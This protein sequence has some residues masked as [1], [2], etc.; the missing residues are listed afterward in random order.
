[1][2]QD[3]LKTLF[4]FICLVLLQ[5]LI[6][7]NVNLFGF[8]NPAFYLF[9]IIIYRFD[10]SKFLLILL[11]FSLGLIIDLFQNSSGAN[12]IATL[13]ISFIRPLMIRFSFGV[14]PD[15]I[16][17]FSMKSRIDSQVL[18][19]I[20]MVIIHQFLIQFI[21]YFDVNLFVVIIRNTVM[22]SIFTFIIIFAT[23]NLLKKKD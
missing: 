2:I 10:K 23:L 18:Y 4:N 8:S 5:F 9:F 21:A 14:N 12:T 11:G 16:S 13:F 22:N 19:V 17:I 7:D 15:N 1:M 6:F 20:L 3:N